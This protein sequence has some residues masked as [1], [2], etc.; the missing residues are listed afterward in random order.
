MQLRYKYVVNSCL[1]ESVTRY[2][3]YSFVDYVLNYSTLILNMQA[4]STKKIVDL[5]FGFIF[6]DKPLQMHR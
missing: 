3:R 1:I 6:L 5:I 4:F 2:N